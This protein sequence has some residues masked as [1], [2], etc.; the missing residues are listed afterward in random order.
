MY[1]YLIIDLYIFY[2]LRIWI[3]FMLYLIKLDY[4]L[5]L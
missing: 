4:D 1:L 2:V 3:V 5:I